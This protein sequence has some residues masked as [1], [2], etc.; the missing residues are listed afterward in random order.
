MVVKYSGV[1][2]TCAEEEYQGMRYLLVATEGILLGNNSSSFE[3]FQK[4]ITEYKPEGIP[5]IVIDARKLTKIDQ[6]YLARLYSI[7]KDTN[8]VVVSSDEKQ[9]RLLS[10]MSQGRIKTADTL[11]RAVELMAEDLPAPQIELEFTAA[12]N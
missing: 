4:K 6:C 9:N 7:S 8:M 5:N 11:D 1:S 10:I 2:C 12:V 3:A